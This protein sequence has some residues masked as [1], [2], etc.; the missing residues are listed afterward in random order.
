MKYSKIKDSV[1][2][3]GIPAKMDS[4]IKLPPR[5]RKNTV[6]FDCETTGLE[7][8]FGSITQFACTS[9]T[10]HSEKSPAHIAN[11]R[12]PHGVLMHPTACLTTGLGF[13]DVTDPRRMSS[14]EFATKLVKYFS[15]LP[16]TAFVAFNSGFDVRFIEDFLYKNA[17]DPYVLKKD[18][19][20][21]LDARPFCLLGSMLKPTRQR[22]KILKSQTGRF[23]SSQVG[24]T[25]SNNLPSYLAH[26][27]GADVKALAALWDLSIKT[28]SELIES[29]NL[30]MNKDQMRARVIE[31]DYF[32]APRFSATSGPSIEASVVLG[33]HPK[34]SNQDICLRIDGIDQRQI[35]SG[36]LLRQIH[37]GEGKK[38]ITTLKTN[39]GPIIALSDSKAVNDLITPEQHRR[40]TKIAQMA[41]ADPKFLEVA[42][43]LLIDRLTQY[44]EPIYFE[45]KRISG[46]FV[47][48]E[49]ALLLQKFHS[50]DPREKAVF[51]GDLVDQRLSYFCKQVLYNNWPQYLSPK[52]VKELDEEVAWRLTTSEKVPWLTIGV[53]MEEIERLLPDCLPR[54]REMLNDYRADLLRLKR[55]PVRRKDL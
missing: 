32:L 30:T 28:S 41:K 39:S 20:I 33:R 3:T 5:L 7:S 42:G 26:D 25:C 16:Q 46:G 23:D 44:A 21:P 34:Y 36:D 53:V 8:K 43:R 40:Y 18:G 14:Y 45:E 19:R 22:I 2:T 55:S 12:L 9:G 4:D 38:F 13:R 6:F 35:R 24:L 47:G 50:A 11:V 29:L 17:L 15:S 48:R 54:P 10:G 52:I 31:A 27:A 51:I 1:T 37:D 49:D